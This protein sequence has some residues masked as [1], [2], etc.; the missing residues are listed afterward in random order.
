M[1]AHVRAH[2]HTDCPTTSHSVDRSVWVSRVTQYLASVAWLFLWCL[3]WQTNLVLQQIFLIYFRNR[4]PKG[5]KFGQKS[6]RLLRF[7]GTELQLMSISYMWKVERH[8]FKFMS[9]VRTTSSNFCWTYVPCR[10][11]LRPCCNVRSPFSAFASESSIQG[12]PKRSP[13]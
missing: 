2:T 6:V 5:Q 10:P 13:S 1:H 9:N 4:I 8:I 3:L 7:H 12:R 11:I